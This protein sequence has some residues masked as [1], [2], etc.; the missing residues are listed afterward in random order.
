MEGIVKHLE[1]QNEYIEKLEAE[2]E[3]LRKLCNRYYKELNS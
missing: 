1:E 2:I 3:R